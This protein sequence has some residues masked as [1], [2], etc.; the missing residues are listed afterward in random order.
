M[1]IENTQPLQAPATDEKDYVPFQVEEPT[2]YIPQPLD[3]K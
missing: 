1:I 3:N 2:E